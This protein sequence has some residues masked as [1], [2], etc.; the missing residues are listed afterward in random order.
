M[1]MPFKN[2]LSKSI[3]LHL[4]TNFLSNSMGLEITKDFKHRNEKILALS[5]T[6][7]RKIGSA[8]G[9]EGVE[10]QPLAEEAITDEEYKKQASRI[11]KTS[12]EKEI[13]SLRGALY[14][15]FLTK[16]EKLDI[17]QVE[18]LKINSP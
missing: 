1:K 13:L 17:E 11:K 3:S 7:L 18:I 5:K 16:Q 14:N 6:D 8:E 15:E 4:I 9:Q 12:L 10:E 2:L